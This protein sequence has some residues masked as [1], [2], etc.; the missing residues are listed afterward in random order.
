[1]SHPVKLRLSDDLERT[2]VTVF[3]RLLLA[4][5]HFVWLTLWGIAVFLMTIL[6]WF[7]T[8]ATGTPWRAAHAFASRYVRYG[9]H[10]YAYVG[11]L[12]D[13][14]PGFGG[15]HGY[16]VDVELPEPGPQNRWTVLLR[17]LLAL[18]V[19]L[20]AS[21]LVTGYWY[22][23]GSSVDSFSQVGGLLTAVALLGWFAI[24]AR[25]RMPRGLR[26]AGAYGVAYNAQLHAYLL[27]V[28]DRYPNSDPLAALDDL[29]TRAEDPIK[30]DVEDDRKRGRATTFF[31][32]LLALPHVAWLFVWGIA[33]YGAAIASWFVQVVAGRPSEGLHR[34][35]ATWLRYGTHVYA[36]VYLLA[37]PYPKFDGRAGAY[38]VELSVAEPQRQDRLTVAFRLVLAIPA[39][40][41]SSAYAGVALVAVVLGWF[42]VL[43]RGE[44]PLGLR[45]AMALWLRYN[46]QLLG[47]VL[48]LTERYPY[49]GPVG[50]EPEP[51]VFLP[52]V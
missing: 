2:R 39:F 21:V 13:P 48:L 36:Y 31:R 25:G 40:L 44:V 6:N 10:V 28:T 34:F 42:A 3:F 5:P 52:P 18:P 32:L 27:L 20:L 43:V 1:M 11:L 51:P 8:L 50:P 47:Y 23:T 49:S 12:A 29:P 30:L 37:D 38:P 19:L 14:Y 22:P 24:L 15:N 26:D 46:Q 35:I 17:L 33:A 16:P 9:V 45:N 41:I 4:I 7:A